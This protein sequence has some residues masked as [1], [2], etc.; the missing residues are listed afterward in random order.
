ME[1]AERIRAAIEGLHVQLE[2]RI[3]LQVT[4]SLGVSICQ[5]ASQDIQSIQRQADQAMYQAKTGGRNRVSL[6]GSPPAP[7]ATMA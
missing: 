7:A 1:L 5:D 6:F 4:A 3:C 2:S